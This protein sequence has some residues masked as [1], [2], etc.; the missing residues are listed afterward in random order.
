MPSTFDGIQQTEFKSN[1]FVDAK[2]IKYIWIQHSIFIVHGHHRL[3]GI[4]ILLC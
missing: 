1:V 3:Q 2:V 4:E